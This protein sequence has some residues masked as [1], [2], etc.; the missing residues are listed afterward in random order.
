MLL[1]LSN[2]LEKPI[3]VI[4]FELNNN[5]NEIALSWHLTTKDKDKV[6]SSVFTKGNQESLKTLLELLNN[7]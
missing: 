4:S 1:Y 5:E 2:S 3:N 7:Q 6:Y